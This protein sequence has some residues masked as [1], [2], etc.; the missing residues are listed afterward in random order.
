M[1]KNK[2]GSYRGSGEQVRAVK[3]KKNATRMKYTINDKAL[4]ARTCEGVMRSAEVL[5]RVP[6]VRSVSQWFALG[7]F[8]LFEL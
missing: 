4:S 3:M 7:I 6:E 8:G 2:N 1:I 5:E